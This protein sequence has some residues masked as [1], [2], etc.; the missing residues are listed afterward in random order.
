MGGH[1]Q[2]EFQRIFSLCVAHGCF[3]TASFASRHRTEEAFRENRA[4]DIVIFFLHTALVLELVMVQ[5]A[6]FLGE[7]SAF[8]LFFFFLNIIR[9]AAPWLVLLGRT[10]FPSTLPS[11]IPVFTQ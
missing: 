11:L 9:A 8:I 5:V 10:V 3:I 7:T 6:A 2:A 4:P 1:D